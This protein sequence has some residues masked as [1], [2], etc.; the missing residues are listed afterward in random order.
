[1]LSL[2]VLLNTFLVRQASGRKSGAQNAIL[3]NIVA[4]TM[5]PYSLRQK[6]CCV[7]CFSCPLLCGRQRARVQFM[8]AG[9]TN[10]S[11]VK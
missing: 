8:L 9:Q 1:M 4:S 11:L 7:G 5:F 10:S 6:E 2:G 3:L